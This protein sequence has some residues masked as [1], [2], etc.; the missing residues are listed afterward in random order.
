MRESSLGVERLGRLFGGLVCALKKMVI[1]CRC[2][3][4]VIEVLG[5]GIYFAEGYRERTRR[6]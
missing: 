4:S 6:G 5:G 2:G 3:V 1:N